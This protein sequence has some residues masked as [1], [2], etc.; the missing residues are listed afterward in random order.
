MPEPLRAQLQAQGQATAEGQFEIVAISAGKGNGWTFP[1]AVLQQSLKLWD[2]VETF[3]DHGD[4]LADGRSLRDLGG[5]CHSPQWDD[6]DQAIRLQLRTAGP[7]GPLVDALGRELLRDT[8]HAPRVGFSADVIFTADSAKTV[9]QIL[10]VLSLDLV[11]HPARGGAFIRALNSVQPSPQHPGVGAGTAQEKPM[12]EPSTTPMPGAA[13]AA[14]PS[15]SPQRGAPP[16]ASS[17]TDVE[18]MR[19]L[20]QM[21]SAAHEAEAA[22][23]LRVQMCGYLLDSGLAASRLPAAAQEPIRKRF[24]GTA[25]EAKDLTAAIDDQRALVAALTAGAIIQGPGRVGSHAAG[26]GQAERAGPRA[27]ADGGR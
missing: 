1:A 12:P 6:F 27:R 2:G 10:R 20:L 17:T 8:D 18:A 13:P 21:Q 24:A 16:P 15:A 25:F 22:H 9:Q 7:S 23:A 3:V 19:A 14:Q 11:F 5:V 4:I 26:S